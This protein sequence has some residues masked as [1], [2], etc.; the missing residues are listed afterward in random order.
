[1]ECTFILS[2]L[3]EREEMIEGLYDYK[4]VFSLGLL[5]VQVFFGNAKA[6]Q[7]NPMVS[8]SW[9]II[10]AGPG[11]LIVLGNLLDRGVDPK[12]IVWIDDAFNAGRIGKYYEYVAGNTRAASFLAYF[13]SCK[14]FEFHQNAHLFSL[15]KLNPQEMCLLSEVIK[16]MQWLTQKMQTRVRSIKGLVRSI[17]KEGATWS[18]VL[19]DL[20]IEAKNV[21]LAMG[22]HPKTLDHKG[23]VRINLDDALHPLKLAQQ[24]RPDDVVAVY[25]VSHSG[26][27]ALK[28]LCQLKVKKIISYSRHSVRYAI[29]RGGYYAYDNTGLKGTTAQ[30]ARE[31]FEK[32]PPANLE[33]RRTNEK[34][35]DGELAGCTKVID[36]VGYERNDIPGL[37]KELLQQFNNK[38]G[39]I[40]DGL[41]G[42]GIAFP[43]RVLDPSGGYEE[44]VGLSKFM[45][46]AQR[47]VPLWLKK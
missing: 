4:K 14:S 34:D 2:S 13:Q 38:T 33:K 31:V 30:W 16:P 26:M 36:A 27:L 3:C 19:D 25:G 46:H 23:V 37:S 7:T 12:T 9:V 40:A 41:F 18:V 21:V 32:N 28:H 24:V 1:M 6:Q 20:C 22:S 8:A 42:V 10:G 29:D 45:L 17:K 35:T 44:A 47:A 11:G 5:L 39:V 43:N 15:S